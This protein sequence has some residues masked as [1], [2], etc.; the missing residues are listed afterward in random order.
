M[1]CYPTITKNKA[2]E[3]A[4]LTI[5]L[6]YPILPVFLAGKDNVWQGKQLYPL[7]SISTLY[8]AKLGKPSL[9]SMRGNAVFPDNSMSAMPVFPDK[10]F[11][12]NFLTN[13]KNLIL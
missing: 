7:P 13:Q 12:K 9:D 5:Q 2:I 10:N 4:I 3:K 11:S 6:N 8:Q 1:Q